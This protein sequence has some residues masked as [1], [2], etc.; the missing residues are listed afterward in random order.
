MT[1]KE[2]ISSNIECLSSAQ[3]VHDERLRIM[4]EFAQSTIEAHR[5]QRKFAIEM[6]RELL[7]KASRE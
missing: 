1:N 7:C 4:G 5:D 6:S 2:N 3:D